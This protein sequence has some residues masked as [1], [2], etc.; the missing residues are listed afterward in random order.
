MIAFLSRFSIACHI[1]VLIPLFSSELPEWY[2]YWSFNW[3]LCLGLLA[4][5]I[6]IVLIIIGKYKKREVSKI[7]VITTTIAL[8]LFLIGVARFLFLLKDLGSFAP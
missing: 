2:P 6:S 7:D 1:P 8:A 5:L 4:A 3:A